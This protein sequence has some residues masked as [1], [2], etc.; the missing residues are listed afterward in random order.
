MQIP[1][2][3]PKLSIRSDCLEPQSMTIIE[4][5]CKLGASH[6]QLWDV[7]NLRS[8]ISPDIAVRLGKVFG[9]GENLWH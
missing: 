2:P 8:S 1:P 6:K 9:G 7:V 3:Y 4:A 5:A